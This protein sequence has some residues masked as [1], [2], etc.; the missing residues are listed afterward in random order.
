VP[1]CRCRS[2]RSPRTHGTC[3]R[4]LARGRTAPRDSAR[5]PGPGTC[6]QAAAGRAGAD[7]GGRGRRRHRRPNPGRTRFALAVRYQAADATPQQLARLH[8]VR[9]RAVTAS[10]RAPWQVV[11]TGQVTPDP[12][13]RDP[14]ST[15]RTSGLQNR[16]LSLRWFEPN[17]RHHQRKRPPGCG[18]AVRRA[19]SF[20]SRYV[21]GCVTMG[22]CVAVCTYIWCIA[23]G[24]N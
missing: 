7:R 19:V 21:S 4:Q 15:M 16:R 24:Q 20:L 3:L 9:P 12:A 17:T 22:R 2:P 6:R 5:R 18:N 1:I 10:R 23:S 11:P 8:G 13:R 14:K